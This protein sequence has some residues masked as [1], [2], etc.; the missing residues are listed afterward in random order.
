MQYN[1]QD[2]FLLYER[3][4][5]KLNGENLAGG[6]QPGIFHKKSGLAA[7]EGMLSA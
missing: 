6:L 4:K 3:L 5:L 1:L 7:L 2:Y